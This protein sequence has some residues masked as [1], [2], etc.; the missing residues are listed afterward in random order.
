MPNEN[1]VP[2]I[3]STASLDD[4]DDDNG[5]VL[6]IFSLVFDVVGVGVVLMLSSG[7]GRHKLTPS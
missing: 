3:T 7:G 4:D 6:T 2:P 1:P 5:V